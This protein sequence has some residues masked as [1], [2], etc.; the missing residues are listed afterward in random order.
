MQTKR[1]RQSCEPSRCCL[2]LLD[3]MPG[4]LDIPPRSLAEPP[5]RWGR[6]ALHHGKCSL[7]GKTSL[8]E[9]SRSNYGFC[10]AWHASKCCFQRQ[11]AKKCLLQDIVPKYLISEKK[12]LVLNLVNKKWRLLYHETSKRNPIPEIKFQN[13]KNVYFKV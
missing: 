1:R 9:R 4:T 2:H 10:R 5:P 13:T 11:A 7:S 3:F 12:K 8:P 6:H